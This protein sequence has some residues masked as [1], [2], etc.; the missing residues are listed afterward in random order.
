[1]FSCGVDPETKVRLNP[2]FENCWIYYCHAGVVWGVVITVQVCLYGAME[3]LLVIRTQWLGRLPTPQST[4]LLIEDIPTRYRSDKALR[5]VFEDVRMGDKVV[6]CRLLKR[7]PELQ[8]KVEELKVAKLELIKVKRNVETAVKANKE[9]EKAA[10][11]TK[12]GEVTKNISDLEADIKGLRKDVDA[13]T[14]DEDDAL[15]KAN[16]K[17][18]EDA[19]ASNEKQ[20]EAERAG[21][22]IVADQG[23][24]GIGNMTGAGMGALTQGMGAFSH[25]IDFVRGRNPIYCAAAFIEFKTRTD[26]DAAR[27]LQFFHDQEEFQMSTPPD[28]VSIIYDDLKHDPKDGQT[29]NL[30]GYAATAGLYFAYLPIVIGITNIAKEV[31]MGPLQAVWAGLAPTMGLQLMVCFLP[32]FLITIFNTF[33]ILKADIFAQKALQ[34]WYFAFQ[35]V[36]VIMATAVG[37]NIN[38]FMAMLVTAPIESFG[39]LADSMPQATHF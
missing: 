20:E 21:K 27:G 1:V 34:N 10:A 36:F 39:V 6:G 17:A 13:K 16:D 18:K 15:Q 35:V 2:D 23:S 7:V 14:K 28:P 19:L 32:T 31:D 37:T 29:R 38:G 8:K 11:E 33:F 9:D 30:L 22:P 4:T 24:I 5:Q 25:G 3:K 12:V 26:A